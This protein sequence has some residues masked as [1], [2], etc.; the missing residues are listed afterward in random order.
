M[1]SVAAATMSHP[2]AGMYSLSALTAV[3][4][5]Y[6]LVEEDT[7]CICAVSR[8]LPSNGGRTMDNLRGVAIPEELFHV[9]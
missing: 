3:A 7:G 6:T 2:C 4:E 8:G 9:S 1:M 5:R